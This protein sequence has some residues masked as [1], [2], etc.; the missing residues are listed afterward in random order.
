M[1]HDNDNDNDTPQ[2]VFE[3]SS[4]VNIS[5]P[6]DILAKIGDIR[7]VGEASDVTELRM[8]LRMEGIPEFQLFRL[9]VKE[10]QTP[11][12]SIYYRREYQDRVYEITKSFGKVSFIK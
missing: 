8:M 9:D 6:E 1:L 3:V 5:N 7:I 4:R 12:L 2:V 11:Q 10:D